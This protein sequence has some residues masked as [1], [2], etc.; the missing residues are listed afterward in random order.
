MKLTVALI[1]AGRTKRGGF[2]IPQLAK[3]G[4]KMPGG[5]RF[6]EKG[7]IKRLDGVEI[8]ELTYREFVLLGQVSKYDLR[9]I[10]KVLRKQGILKRR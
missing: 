9:P 3:L 8:P 4:V 6:P 1:N 10:R 7:W 5:G 2:N